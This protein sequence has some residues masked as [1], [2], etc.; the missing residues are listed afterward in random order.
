MVAERATKTGADGKGDFRPP[1]T[2]PGSA[3]DKER[4]EV[5]PPITGAAG[6]QDTLSHQ[7]TPPALGPSPRPGTVVLPESCPGQSLLHPCSTWHSRTQASDYG[8]KV[9][10]PHHASSQ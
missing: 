9:F 1:N 4:G 2:V 6:R 10:L 7:L 5:P 3:G 8:R